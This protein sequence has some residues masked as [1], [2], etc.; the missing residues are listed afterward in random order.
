MTLLT[1]YHDVPHDPARRDRKGWQRERPVGGSRE[2]TMRRFFWAAVTI[3][4]GTA[5]LAGVIALKTAIYLPHF[6][7]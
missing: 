2:A 4:L 7:Y 3:M 6:A 1:H 5:A